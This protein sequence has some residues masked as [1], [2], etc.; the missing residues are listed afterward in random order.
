MIIIKRLVKKPVTAGT[1]LTFQNKAVFSPSD[2]VS[3]ISQI[4]ELQK[5]QIGLKPGEDNVLMLIVGD[6]EYQMTDRTQM[7][8]V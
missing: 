1:G 3:L 4:E 8:F 6:N 7:V 2:V 5:C